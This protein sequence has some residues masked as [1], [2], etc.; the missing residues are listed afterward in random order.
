MKAVRIQS[1]AL[2][3]ALFIVGAVAHAQSDR[4]TITGT[5]SDQSGAVLPG[6][7]VLATNAETK[8]VFTGV[9]NGSGIYTIPSLPVGVYSLKVTD[10]GFEDYERTGISPVADQV[11]TADVRMTVGA[12]TETVTVSGTPALDTETSTE[13]MTMEETAIRELPLNATGGRNALNLMVETSPNVGWGSSIAANTTQNWL[14][15]SG[16]ETLSNSIFIDGTN[17]TAGNQGM[18]LTPGQDALQEMQFQTNVTDAELSQTGGGAITYVL[19][20]GTNHFHGSAFEYLQNEDLNANTWSSKQ[21]LTTCAAGDAACRAE[22]ARQTDRFN[23]YGGSAGGPLWKNHSFVFGDFEYY[24]QDNW[25][26]NPIGMTVPTAQLLSGDLSPLLTQG[27]NTGTITNPATGTPW[28]NPCTGQPYQYGQVFDPETQQTIN[29]VT[30]ATPFAGNIIPTGRLSSVSQKIAAAYNQYYKPTV[31]RLVGGNFPSL[32]SGNPEYWKKNFDIKIDHY[33]SDRHH[34]SGSLDYESDDSLEAFGPFYWNQG[35]FAS[36]WSFAD[37]GNKMARVVDNYSITPKLINTFSADW[38]LNASDQVPTNKINPTD[39][40]F[41]TGAGV[42]PLL[43]YGAGVN[44][45]GFSWLGS[46]WDLYMNFNSYN[47]ADTVAWQL[48]RHDVK[49]GAQW[50]AQQLNSA[51]YTLNE[52]YYSFPSDTG[53]PTDPGLTP[54]V[55]STLSAFLLGDV[56]SSQLYLRNGY[57]PRQKYMALFA[58]DDYKVNLRLTLNLG[59]RWD[60]TFPGHM[61]NGKWE[62]WGINAVNPNWAPYTGAWVFSQNS[63]T[64]FEKDMI[65]HQLGPHIGADYR[66]TNKLVARA[67]YGL[68]YVPLG[69]FS[70]GGADYYPAN[71][72][73]DAIGTNLV[74]STVPGGY[75]FDWDQGYPGTT[76]QPVQN[77]SDTL[78]GDAGRAMYIDPDYLELGHTQTFYAGIQYELAKNMVLDARYLGTYGGGLHDY[79]HGVDASWPANWGQYSNLLQAGKINSYISDAADAASVG[80]PYPYPGFTGP[81]YAAIAPY[82]QLARNGFIAQMI[83]TPAYNAE[84]VYNSFVAELKVRNTHGLYVDWSYTLSKSTSDSASN[85]S[86]GGLSN[87]SNNWSSIF[88][89]PSDFQGAKNWVMLNDQRNLFKGY[90]TYDLPLGTNQQWLNQS[91]VLNYLVGGWTV[92]YY[93]AYGS[94]LPMSRVG[95]PVTLPYYYDSA[96]RAFFANGANAENMKNHFNGHL[97]LIDITSGRNNDFSPSSFAPATTATPF[98]NTPY[99]YNHWRWNSYPAEE[100]ASLVKRFGFGPEGRYQA[101]IRGEFYNLFNRHYFS[102]PDLYMNDATFGDVTGVNGNR[103]G[104]V[105]ARF[106]W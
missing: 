12:P 77:S 46:D 54:Y 86:S 40:G 41:T 79:G 30:C 35:P 18:A 64:T 21:F 7:V 47:Y 16:G 53:G 78:F 48:G 75:S 24:K 81:A 4:A 23:D 72:D 3:I 62:N 5:V 56:N 31:N 34:I 55:G 91:H 76:I 52:Q 50:E 10:A 98:G 37:I 6:A 105:A 14:S 44:G 100:N 90:L 63:G 33:F 36:I 17:A 22:Y 8:A 97:N 2:L 70:S 66:L 15:I 80:V 38:N 42:F 29:G 101:Q 19:K 43:E 94:G 87:F 9:S 74:Q 61:E 85:G 67:S 68:F 104:Q 60:L 32:A 13:A 39:Y 92:G 96:Q 20:S 93:G 27:T 11:I 58:Q 84:S 57:Y 28:I 25:T 103:I 49:L 88:Q 99:S 65:Y 89:S 51:N 83:G 1:C 45:I 59:V 95:S 26:I 69:A 106:E 102:A 82:P 71:Q 73:P